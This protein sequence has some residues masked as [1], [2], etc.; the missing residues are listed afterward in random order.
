MYNNVVIFDKNESGFSLSEIVAVFV[1]IALAAT[2]A[3][4]KFTSMI[5]T[6]RAKEA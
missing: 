1:I 5:E 6:T 2:L 4:P 3:L